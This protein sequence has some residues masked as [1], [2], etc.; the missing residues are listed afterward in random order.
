MSS[1]GVTVSLTVV[2]A[3]HNVVAAA[4]FKDEEETDGLG[5]EADAL[6]A[7]GGA[8]Q[9]GAAFANM[10]GAVVGNDLP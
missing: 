2:V 10:R 4:E 7:T 1:S 8:G 6:A 5:A 9:K 3:S